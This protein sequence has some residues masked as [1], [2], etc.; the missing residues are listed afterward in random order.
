[1]IYTQQS[2]LPIIFQVD[3]GI[4]LDVAHYLKRNN[5]AFPKVLVVSG[6]NHSFQYAEKIAQ[7]N[8]WINYTINDNTFKNVEALKS[9][10]NAHNI[11][12]L[13][14]VGGGKVIDTVKRASYLSNTNNLSI[15]TIISN[16]GLISPVAVIK[17]DSGRTESLPGMMPLG[18]IIDLDIIK[19]SPDKYIE[20]AVGDVFSNLSSTNDWVYA[21][22]M[23]KERMN[24]IA[25]H[26]AK[27]AANSLINYGNIEI[28]SKSFL[29]LVV[30]GL[31]NSGIAMSLAGTSR[32]CSGSEHSLSHAIDYLELSKDILHGKQVG[33][34]NLF[35]LFLQ[36]KLE[37]IHLE[38][39]Q[40]A[41]IPLDFTEFLKDK[42]EKNIKHIFQTAAEMRPGRYT[43]LNEF[44]EESFITGLDRYQKT[45]QNRSEKLNS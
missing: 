18:I 25:F 37:N 20:A 35:T 8:D 9:Y 42:S 17:N 3:E 2:H 28:K 16:D 30:Q 21:F 10:V 36:G 6:E 24:D 32:P 29:R 23:E 22:K 31:V 38:F 12:L 27:S 1:M 13:I 33:S 5:L 11:D 4:I 26:L 45:L 44:S 14:G 34:L 7:K 41:N 19:E 15:P 43:I 40:I 39:A